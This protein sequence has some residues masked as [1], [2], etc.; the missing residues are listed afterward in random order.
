MAKAEDRILVDAVIEATMREMDV[1]WEEIV[2]DGRKKEVYRPRVMMWEIIRS[3]T[4]LSYPQIARRFRRDHSTVVYG[5]RLQRDLLRSDTELA[6][7]RERI[8]EQALMITKGRALSVVEMHRSNDW[9]RNVLEAVA[10]EFETT[11]SRVLAEDRMTTICKARHFA[12]SIVYKTTRLSQAQVAKW[13]DLD[14]ATVTHAIDKIETLVAN[15]AAERARWERIVVVA[16]ELDNGMRKVPKIDPEALERSQRLAAAAEE[17]SRAKE[18]VE[19]AMKRGGR[20]CDV[21]FDLASPRYELWAEVLN[22]RFVEAMREAHPEREVPL[23][24]RTEHR[25]AA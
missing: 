14:R 17:R 19:R 7:T 24:Q 25:A 3:F 22:E 10:Y 21:E 1:T 2:N 16:R 23:R 18:R 5:V 20:M 6:A 9:K 15:D 12:V 8:V 11:A 4:A 13:V